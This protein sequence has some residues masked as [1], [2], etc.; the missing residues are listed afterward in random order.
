[1]HMVGHQTPG[2]DLHAMPGR[3]LGH[4][5]QVRLAIILGVENRQGTHA[6]LEDMVGPAGEHDPGETR[7]GQIRRVVGDGSGSLLCLSPEFPRFAQ[8]PRLPRWVMWYGRPGTAIRGRRAIA[9]RPPVSILRVEISH[10]SPDSGGQ[11]RDDLAPRLPLPQPLFRFPHNHD[12]MVLR[13]V[14][15]RHKSR[16][17][18]PVAGIHRN[19]SVDRT[20]G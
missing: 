3:R 5:G 2:P 8:I 16:F 11:N 17:T 10:V 15:F 19:F 9:R 18:H 7:H 12:G 14:S 13:D 1:M 6:P 4:Q 20:A